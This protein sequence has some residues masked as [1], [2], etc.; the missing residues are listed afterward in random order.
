[1][2]LLVR[3]RPQRPR[4]PKLLNDRVIGE[5]DESFMHQAATRLKSY[6][7]SAM[8]MINCGAASATC[9]CTVSATALGTLAIASLIMRTRMAF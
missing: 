4:R 9:S 3:R 2:L 1:M 8:G 7:Q 6:A 5:T